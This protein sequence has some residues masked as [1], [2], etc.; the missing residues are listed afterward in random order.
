MAKYLVISGT[1]FGM[2]SS[3]PTPRLNINGS[4]I[5]LTTDTYS[6]KSIYV[7]GST[8]YRIMKNTTTHIVGRTTYTNSES[9]TV[10]SDL[11]A[12]TTHNTTNSI[13]E[14]MS[15]TT[16]LTMD[17]FEDQNVSDTVSTYMSKTTS[18]QTTYT[19]STRYS[20]AYNAAALT[21]ATALYGFRE[22]A[23]LIQNVANSA[24]LSYTTQHNVEYTVWNDY[25]NAVKSKLDIVTKED[26]IKSY[27][28]TSGE[29][30]STTSYAKTNF[31]MSPIGM[32]TITRWR[33][34]VKTESRSAADRSAF[35][36]SVPS[37][38]VQGVT[39]LYSTVSYW[40][41]TCITVEYKVITMYKGQTSKKEI[42]YN[43]DGYSTRQSQYISGYT[44]KTTYDTAVTTTMW[45]GIA[46][47]KPITV[48]TGYSGV[49]NNSTSTTAWDGYA[50]MTV[51]TFT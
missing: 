34:S 9:M 50:D 45:E 22:S 6:D 48:T 51:S 11:T 2:T 28:G 47:N 14:G 3:A 46:H 16:A 5:P 20:T 32:A 17:D 1:T 27:K 7:S 49:S 23:Y 44:G 29:L 41:S 39:S 19:T 26:A 40:K 35:M 42:S 38:N 12:T 24:G 37:S 13:T 33:T 21:G 4:Y 15:S 36:S 30:C 10:I 43:Y 18:A 31:T 8:K 25:Q